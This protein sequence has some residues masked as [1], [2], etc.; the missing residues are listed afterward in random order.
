MKIT[1][2]QSNH[3]HSENA[4]L[5]SVLRPTMNSGSEINQYLPNVYT[6]LLR[7][8]LAQWYHKRRP[9]RPYDGSDLY[10]ELDGEPPIFFRNSSSSPNVMLETP[11]DIDTRTRS[12]SFNHKRTRQEFVGSRKIPIPP[13][14]T[15][16]PR[17]D[18]RSISAPT[19][20]EGVP[21]S[22]IHLTDNS[23]YHGV[24][25]SVISAPPHFDP[26]QPRHHHRRISDTV[27]S[28]NLGKEAAVAALHSL[29]GTAG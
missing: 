3:A 23:T 29:Q 17:E 22:P 10:E 25:V 14:S 15:Q 1:D 27:R 4:A 28:T 13:I 12:K 5:S 8:S 2:E 24:K 16:E 19:E 9:I 21:Q 7:P 26:I 20:I 18:C 11:N 6:K